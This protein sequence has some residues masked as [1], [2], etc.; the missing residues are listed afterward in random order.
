M[1]VSLTNQAVPHFKCEGD[2]S[3]V[4]SCDLQVVMQTL[5]CVLSGHASLV[6][7]WLRSV[8]EVSLGISCLQETPWPCP[9]WQKQQSQPALQ[10][11]SHLSEWHPYGAGCNCDEALP[12][13]AGQGQP[14]QLVQP[15]HT[16]HKLI[17][18]HLGSLLQVQAH[19]VGP[20]LCLWCA[21]LA[22]LSKG[23]GGHLLCWRLLVLHSPLSL[24][25]V[26][27]VLCVLQ[28]M[29]CSPAVCNALRGKCS[30]QAAF[31]AEMHGL[32]ES[33]QHV[34]VF[35]MPSANQCTFCHGAG[36]PLTPVGV[37]E[38]TLPAPVSS[39]CLCCKPEA[40]TGTRWGVEVL[41]A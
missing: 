21:G 28:L 22:V 35:Q 5:E 16:R 20:H 10:S 41:Q 27:S 31:S 30:C 4:N 17:S 1:D 26:E 14:P 29:P 18:W 3:I 9:W 38:C 37:T 6:H 13:L 8:A 12:Y 33:R 36:R 15:A 24:H 40:S 11:G 32:A 25:A 7:L 39:E 19:A 34:E 23:L 2:C